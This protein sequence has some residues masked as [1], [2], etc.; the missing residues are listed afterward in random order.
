[1]IVRELMEGLPERERSILY[2]RFFENMT[3]PEIAERV[4]VSQSYLS[5]ILRKALIDLRARVPE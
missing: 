3:Q 1:M 4:G 5:R 2:M